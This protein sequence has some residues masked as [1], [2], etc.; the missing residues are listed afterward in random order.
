[1]QKN[2]VDHVKTRPLS[3]KVVDES[4]QNVT[5]YVDLTQIPSFAKLRERVNILYITLLHIFY[6]FHA[7]YF[8]LIFLNITVYTRIP[9]ISLKCFKCIFYNF[10]VNI[11]RP[12]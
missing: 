12:S 10:L 5:D 8:L 6:Y 9:Y 7:S 3:K 4:G 2:G 1:M 11:K